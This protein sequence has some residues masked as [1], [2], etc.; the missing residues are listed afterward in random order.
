MYAL[1]PNDDD[2]D[3]DDHKDEHDDNDGHDHNHDHNH[4]HDHDEN[5]R[6]HSDGEEHSDEKRITQNINVYKTI[7]QRYETGNKHMFQIQLHYSLNKMH[8]Y[9]ITYM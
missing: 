3:H 4:D 8:V 2:D 9:I 1:L 7:L 5:D 6:D